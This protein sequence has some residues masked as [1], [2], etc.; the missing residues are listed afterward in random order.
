MQQMF[1]KKQLNL[2]N[3]VLSLTLLSMVNSKF[4]IRPSGSVYYKFFQSFANELRIFSRKIF[5]LSPKIN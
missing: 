2:Q 4:I 5:N 3:K 1:T